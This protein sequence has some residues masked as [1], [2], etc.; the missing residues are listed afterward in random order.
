MRALRC[1]TSVL[2]LATTL[3]LG[4]ASPAVAQQPKS[5]L[6]ADLMR[7]IEEVEKK[8]VDLAGAI[9]A[10]KFAWRPGEGVRSVSEVLLHVASDNYFI[11]ALGGVAAPAETGIKADDYNTTLTYEKRPMNKEAAIAALQ[12]SFA[13]VKKALSATPEAKLADALPQF[14]E[15]GT[16]RSLWLL[17]ATHIHEHLG[18]LIAYARMNG[19]VPPWS[20]PGG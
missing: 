8:F 7:D 11:P 17:E 16:V 3:A 14:G 13:H 5:G 20:R 18:Q 2:P 10:E 15:N 6:V 1:I 9:P 12:Q 4:T 19:V